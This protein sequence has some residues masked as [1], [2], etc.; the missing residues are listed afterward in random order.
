M[1][2]TGKLI[3]TDIVS[4]PPVWWFG[5]GLEIGLDWKVLALI[6]DDPKITDAMLAEKLNVTV[7]IIECVV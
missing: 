2:D 6:S 7:K 4:K 5:G 1:A 3:K